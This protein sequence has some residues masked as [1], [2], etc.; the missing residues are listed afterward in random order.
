MSQMIKRYSNRFSPYRYT[1]DH[2]ILPIIFVSIVL[3]R[4]NANFCQEVFIDFM[5]AQVKTLS[6]LAYVIKIYQ[7]CLSLCS[8]WSKQKTHMLVLFLIKLL[9]LWSG[10][11]LVNRPL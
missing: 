6:F 10:F 3:S 2:T 7:V 5:A 9:I 8:N 4:K 1:P 11:L